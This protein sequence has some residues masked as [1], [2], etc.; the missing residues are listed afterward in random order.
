MADIRTIDID[1]GLE[2]ARRE[3]KFTLR[4]L[5]RRESTRAFVA[6]FEALLARWPALR[7]AQ[8]ARWDA[9]DDADVDVADADDDLD[10]AVALTQKA[11]L[12]VLVG[13]TT[14]STFASSATR[15]PR[16]YSG[17]AS[18]VRSRAWT[19]GRRR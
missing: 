4:R 17:S 5:R 8:L 6:A 16:R 18:R 3:L 9:E 11:L 2:T 15:R 10:D 14:R 7:D 12:E 19:G 1:E 13:R